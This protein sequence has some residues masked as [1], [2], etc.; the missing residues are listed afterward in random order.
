MKN[1]AATLL[2]LVLSLVT[3]C[4]PAAP[5]STPTP[6]PTATPVEVTATKPEHLAGIW[7]SQLSDGPAYFRFDA[8]GTVHVGQSLEGLDD[9]DSRLEGT[10]WFE[11]GLYHE[12]NALCAGTYVYEASLQIQ[13][14]RAVRARMNEI[15]VPGMECIDRRL[16]RLWVLVRLD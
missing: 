3:A 5:T 8:D 2:M 11:D 6:E 12:E 16:R 1:T 4:T 9:A 14:G 10:F 13:E 15:E 7:V